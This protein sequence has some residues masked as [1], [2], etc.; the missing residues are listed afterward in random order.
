MS[1]TTA[2]PN[3]ETG[4]PPFHPFIWEKGKMRDLGTL[5]GSVVNSLNGLNDR[6]EV[7]GSMTLRGEQQNHAFLWNGE[8]LIDLGTFGGSGSDAGAINDAG[9]VVGWGGTTQF[10]PIEGSGQ[11]SFLWRNGVKI[12]L[13]ATPGTDQSDA[14]AINSRTQIV[15]DSF[16]CDFSVVNA[17]LWEKGEIMDLNTLFSPASE[18]HLFGASNINDRGEIAGLATM[19]NGDFHAFL[20]TPVNDNA[21]GIRQ[22]SVTPRRITAAEVAAI[23]AYFGHRHF[24]FGRWLRH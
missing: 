15:G 18:L 22:V 17:Y 16:S 10:C 12:D 19:P 9:D 13:G 7:V 24:R 3:P 14:A 23:R 20:L 5:G 21:P 1:Y 4:I 2:S 11:R 6:G 8:R